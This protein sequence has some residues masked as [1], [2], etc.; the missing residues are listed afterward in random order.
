MQGAYRL[1]PVTKKPEDVPIGKNW[2]RT[3]VDGTDPNWL[4]NCYLKHN[5]YIQV[6]ISIIKQDF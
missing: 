5:K 2:I 6:T 4:K 3:M 1:M